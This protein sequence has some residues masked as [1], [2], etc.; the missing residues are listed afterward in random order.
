LIGLLEKIGRFNSVAVITAIAAVASL[1]VTM[2]AVTA[3]GSQGFQVNVEIAAI[4]S[5]CV[6]AAVTP[7]IAWYLV[8][9]LLRLSAVEQEMRSLASY[10]SLTGL[11]SRHAFFDS[12]GNYVPLAKREQK[13]FAVMIID[14]DHF[15]SIND[16]YGHPAGDAVLKL[17]ADVVNSVARRSDI[18]GRLGGEEFAMVLPSTTTA[19]ALEF[20]ERLHGAINKAVLKYRGDAIRYTAS[21]GLTEFDTDSEDSIDELLARADLALYRTATFNPQLNQAA[22]G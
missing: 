14:L 22:A 10:D 7:P 5:V 19:E 1:C 9:L 6:A 20:S 18:I 16:R 12:A 13:P 21:I 2:V 4:L 17:F 3:L 8:D 15:K 11:L